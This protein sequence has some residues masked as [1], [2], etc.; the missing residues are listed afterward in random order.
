MHF[1][2]RIEVMGQVCHV[3]DKQNVMAFLV[4]KRRTETFYNFFGANCQR[5]EFPNNWSNFG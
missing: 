5:S 4:Q 1:Q 3:S 2:D